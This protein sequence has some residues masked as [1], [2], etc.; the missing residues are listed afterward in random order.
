MA[1][2]GSALTTVAQPPTPIPAQ[3]GVTAGPQAA[4]S[5]GQ[6]AQQ[7]DSVTLTGRTAESQQNGNGKDNGAQMGEASVF[8][9]AERQSF[10]AANGSGGNQTASTAPSLPVK[11]ADEA[12]LT[13]GKAAAA[14]N[15]QTI[16]ATNQET[17]GPSNSVDETAATAATAAPSPS[18]TTT[19][20]TTNGSGAADTPIA[21]LAQLDNT[22]Q[23]MGIDP[24]SISLFSR[25]AML[26]YANDPAALRVLVQTLQNGA[27]QL[28]S[29]AQSGQAVNSATNGQGPAAPNIQS[30]LPVQT[31]PAAAQD[32][33]NQTQDVQNNTEQTQSV[34]DQAMGSQLTASG[35]ATAGSSL[36][37]PGP[38][39]SSGGAS[40]SSAM[41]APGAFTGSNTFVMQ[42]GQLNSTFAA[43]EGRQFNLIQQ[44]A[45]SGQLLNVSA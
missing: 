14:S 27:D 41:G 26:L 16:P 24:Q 45:E 29:A 21:E 15:T 3:T 32:S 44:N 30:I 18:A 25:M 22:L 37:V 8:F 38:I 4:V 43:L 33:E 35:S 28:T 17:A 34:V 11:I 36:P 1:T 42:L 23:Q 39:E 20:S 19:N 5:G 7:A 2:V 31:Q 12:T 10:R 40:A 13:G 6:T 9:F